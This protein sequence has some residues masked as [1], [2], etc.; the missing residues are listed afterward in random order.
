MADV[1]KQALQWIATYKDS[2][3]PELQETKG[4]VASA[5]EYITSTF[6]KSAIQIGTADQLIIDS[7]REVHGQIS[8]INRAAGRS[9]NTLQSFF[10]VA[11]REAEKNVAIM[12]SLGTVIDKDDLQ[13]LSQEF[14]NMA[15]GVEMLASDLTRLGMESPKQL[16]RI[17]IALTELYGAEGV[18]KNLGESLSNAIIQSGGKAFDELLMLVGG[19][20]PSTFAKAFKEGGLEVKKR[21]L[22]TLLDFKTPQWEVDKKL[23]IDDERKRG[24]GAIAE[25]V[26]VSSR[27]VPHLEDFVALWRGWRESTIG[28]FDAIFSALKL[29]IKSLAGWLSAAL[30]IGAPL[31]FLG[32][33]LFSAFE[34][35]FDIFRQL[36]IIISIP[37]QNALLELMRLAQPLFPVIFNLFSTLTQLLMPILTALAKLL[38]S[39]LLPILKGAVLG[40]SW[41]AEGIQNV[42][43]AIEW[44]WDKFSKTGLG[45][46][47]IQ[48][49]DLWL[50]M[51]E[52][53]SGESRRRME[54]GSLQPSLVPELESIPAIRGSRPFSEAQPLPVAV[55]DASS[56][57]I[58]KT[59][60]S[61][62][63]ALTV[64][65]RISDQ[66]GIQNDIMMD[67]LPLLD[68]TIIR[69]WQERFAAFEVA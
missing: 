45:K 9:T 59:A 13:A 3:S 65:D 60:I 64:L 28:G 37:L 32:Q 22:D 30:L 44:A 15:G 7:L 48:T 31:A 8:T 51:M 24:E 17:A 12:R 46:V 25:T 47:F 6:R 62:D 43:E 16:A 39:V 1:T 34:P 35:L 26:G 5:W 56:V 69:P 19:K 27:K 14:V 49:W 11:M 33:V 57:P 58:L 54:S 55:S 67:G 21:V 40:F 23:L 36:A 53:M 68:P 66:L 61:G 41:L 52:D 4:F 10:G 2:V 18:S 50:Q 20:F 38:S 29:S 42:F 63:R